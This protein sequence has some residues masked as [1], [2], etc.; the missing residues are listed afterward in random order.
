MTDK[1]YVPKGGLLFDKKEN[2]S[3]VQG[4][5]TDDLNLQSSLVPASAKASKNKPVKSV[6]PPKDPSV[7]TPVKSVKPPKDPSTNK[8]V[9]STPLTWNPTSIPTTTDEIQQV[10]YGTNVMNNIIQ[11]VRRRNK[12]RIE[13][14]E[15][16]GSS[17]PNPTNPYEY[18][19]TSDWT[20]GGAN[21]L[22]PLVDG[23]TYNI[24][25]GID[26]SPDGTHIVLCE[27]WNDNQRSYTM[28]TAFDFSTAVIDGTKSGVDTQPQNIRWCDEGNK[29]TF[30]LG[31][32][33]QI[34]V[35]ATSTAYECD[36]TDSELSRAAF[37]EFGHGTG[38]NPVGAFVPDGTSFYV[39]IEKSGDSHIYM[40]KATVS[41]PFDLDTITGVTDLDINDI[42]SSIA[43]SSNDAMLITDDESIMMWFHDGVLYFCTMSTPGDV[44]T[45]VA[46]E[47]NKLNPDTGTTTA[48]WA[49]NSDYSKHI[50][51]SKDNTVPKISIYEPA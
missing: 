13:I 27:D 22:N 32:A 23:Q 21:D 47:T 49:T 26:M 16:T 38:V 10:L 29:Y 1:F 43:A 39:A 28:S 6:K 51:A 36:T 40:A 45:W 35:Y 7:N 30:T 41:T 25:G 11:Y 31:S 12:K 44:T 19:K 33:N 14:L 46:D 4:S 24:T 5:D 18:V 34:A 15:D 17:Q 37:T 20:D 3:N 8:P 48:G 42:T 2:F 9:M 50:F